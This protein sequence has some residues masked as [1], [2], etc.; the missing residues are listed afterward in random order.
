MGCCRSPRLSLRLG[1]VSRRVRYRGTTGFA[2][3][4]KHLDQP[5]FCAFHAVHRHTCIQEK[6]KSTL[7]NVSCKQTLQTALFTLETEGQGAFSK[8]R[9][10]SEG[11]IISLSSEEGL[12][13]PAAY[14]HRTFEPPCR[15]RSPQL[16]PFAYRAKP[17]FYTHHFTHIGPFGRGIGERKGFE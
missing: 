7:I 13:H 5:A 16:P 1:E 2:C 6:P 9:I 15:E 12:T 4:A 11:P 10:L 14:F 17:Q 3:R 8:F